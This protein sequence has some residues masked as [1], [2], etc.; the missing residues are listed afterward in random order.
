[1]V[2]KT[3][4]DTIA[5]RLEKGEEI[6]SSIRAICEKEGV[7]AGTIQGL[8]AA[9]HSVVGIFD[10]TKNA[11]VSNTFDQDMEITAL[12]GNV[13]TKDGKLY[14]HIHA[15]LGDDKGLAHGG[16]LNEAVVS[17]TCELF[18]RKLDMVI[19][20]KADPKTGINLMVF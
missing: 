13:S 6:V 10:F 18:I 11:Y 8:G 15:T 17:A 1:M 16:H 19:E 7:K 9:D 20:R 2:Y 3:C 4:G 12:I 14:L 5:V